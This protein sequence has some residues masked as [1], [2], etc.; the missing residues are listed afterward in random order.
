MNVSCV[1]PE[2]HLLVTTFYYAWVWRPFPH[3]VR[4]HYI[5]CFACWLCVREP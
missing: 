4:R 2:D 5:R 1:R 3:F